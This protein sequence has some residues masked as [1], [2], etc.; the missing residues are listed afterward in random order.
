MRALA[1]TVLSGR[2]GLARL[3]ADAAMPDGLWSGPGFV[4]VSRTDDELSIVC[5]ES[6]LPAGATS[7]PGWRM[8]RL[9]GPFDFDQVGILRDFIAPLADVG[10]GIFAVSTFDTDYVLVKAGHLARALAALADAGHRRLD[11]PDN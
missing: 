8:I 2:Y 7:E 3:A 1:F 5:E 9:A 11:A 10:V 6:M 4:S